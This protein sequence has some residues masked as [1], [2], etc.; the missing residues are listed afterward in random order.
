MVINTIG[1][2]FVHDLADLYD[3]EQRFLEAQQ[4]M[5]TKAN[6]TELR[7][8]LQ[9]HIDQTTQQIT[10]LQQIYALLG[11]EPMRVDCDAAI[12]LVQE[13]N[14]AI[15]GSSQNLTLRDS[16]IAGAIAKVEHYEIA[17]YRGLIASAELTNK[18]AILR[19][20]RQNLEQEEQT[21]RKVEQSAPMLLRQAQQA[22]VVGI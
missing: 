8:M 1:D 16:V 10:N 3:A 13:G 12:G 15:Q 18:E 20:L 7:M 9:E 21:A 6:A 17:S 19:L 11:A 4:E 2:K 14:K 5:L 22:Q